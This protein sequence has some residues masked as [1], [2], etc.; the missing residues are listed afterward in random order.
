[1][2]DRATC[3]A[4]RSPWNFFGVKFCADSIQKSFGWDYKP[5]SPLCIRM[6]KKKIIY[7]RISLSLSLSLS[8]HDTKLR[9]LGLFPLKEKLM[10]NKAVLVFKACIKHAPPYLKQLFICSNTRAASWF[11][12]L[13]KPGIDLFKTNFSFSGASQWNTIPT[14]IKSCKSLTSF[15]TQLHEWFRSILLLTKKISWFV[16]WLHMHV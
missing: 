13:P 6:K 9:Y 14:E 16:M 1:M 11:I 10:F 2:G 7:A 4:L 12:A 15:R 3:S 8:L 5:R